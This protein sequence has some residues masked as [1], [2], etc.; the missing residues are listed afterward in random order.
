MSNSLWPHGLQHARLPCPSP[1]PGAYSISCP[2]SGWCHPTISSSVIPFS[3]CLQSFPASGSFPMSRLFISGGQSIGA[4]ASASVLP[5]NI[6]GWFPSGLTG[7]ISLQSKGLL[8]L[9]QDSSSSLLQHYS[10]KASILWHSAFQLSHW[11]TIPFSRGYFQS[12]DWTQLSC[13]A[14]G[15]FTIWTTRIL[16][17]VSYPF[18]SRS[19]LPRNQTGVSC[20]ASRLFTAEPPGKPPRA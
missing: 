15:F 16:E 13:I 17:W 9:L 18:S 2:T 6:Q 4:S 8:Q 10:S 1:T 20:I 12:R 11:V 14:G 19:S 5:M 7:L 3:S